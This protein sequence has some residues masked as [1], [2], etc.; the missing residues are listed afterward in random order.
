MPSLSNDVCDNHIY[1]KTTKVYGTYVG[2]VEMFSHLY[3]ENI[4]PFN[5]HRSAP[6]VFSLSIDT[7][8][9]NNTSSGYISSKDSTPEG[10]MIIKIKYPYVLLH[11]FYFSFIP[12]T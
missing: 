9:V 8:Y 2:Y 3:I 6:Y 11:A 10:A 12:K 1:F 7:D 4:S 5:T